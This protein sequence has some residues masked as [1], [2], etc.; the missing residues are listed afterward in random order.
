MCK[1]V[2]CGKPIDCYWKTCEICYMEECC[3]A[4]AEKNLYVGGRF[5]GE[6][7]I[8]DDDKSKPRV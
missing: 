7:L 6:K 1:C 4:D 8:K 3:K 5:Y 2:K